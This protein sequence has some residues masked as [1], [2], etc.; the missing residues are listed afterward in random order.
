M[1]SSFS[2]LTETLHEKYEAL[3]GNSASGC[4]MHHCDGG[5]CQVIRN[6][7]P[8]FHAKQSPK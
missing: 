1:D 4:F 5:C 8:F 2:D 6:A 7:S 3:I